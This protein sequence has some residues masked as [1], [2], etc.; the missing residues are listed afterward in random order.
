VTSPP[1]WDRF[2]VE[3]MLRH[4]DVIEMIARKGRENLASDV[5]ARYAIYHAAELLAEAA[6][7]SSANF[8][9]SN[10]EIRWRSLSALRRSLA[11]PYDVDAGSVDLEVVWRFATNDAP[12]LKR[13]L[14]KARFPP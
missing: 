7:H 10:E 1:N 2:L 3:E 13:G 14:S 8:R 6:K 4:I 12:K 9:S 11:H 5:T